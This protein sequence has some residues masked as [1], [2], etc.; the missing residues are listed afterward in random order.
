MFTFSSKRIDDIVIEYPDKIAH[1]CRQ[2]K[3]KKDNY[4]VGKL[5]GGDKF[6][7]IEF[8]D[9]FLRIDK[10]KRFIR[11]TIYSMVDHNSNTFLGG[12]E[13]LSNGQECIMSFESNGTF[14]FHEDISTK[15]LFKSSTWDLFKNEMTNSSD[16]IV[17]EGR[18]FR[19]NNEGIITSTNEELV[20]PIIAGLFIIEEKYRISSEHA[21]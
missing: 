9:H 1:N 18:T 7:F 2:Y 20:L 15:K 14:F 5:Y 10:Q 12:Y 11:N 8:P 17:Y 13:F 16:I 21:G 4:V 3:V 19:G 6:T